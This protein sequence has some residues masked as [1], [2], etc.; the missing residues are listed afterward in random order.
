MEGSEIWGIDDGIDVGFE[1]ISAWRFV[2]FG[3]VVWR[4]V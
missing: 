3:K 1:M 2:E 4:L